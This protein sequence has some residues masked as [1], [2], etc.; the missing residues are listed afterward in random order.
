MVA[1]IHLNSV[2]CMPTASNAQST[3]L[4]Q[5]RAAAGLHEWEK[6]DLV[7][8]PSNSLD[9]ARDSSPPVPR[10]IEDPHL[11]SNY[12]LSYDRPAAD[13][14]DFKTWITK[15]F[16]KLLSAEEEAPGTEQETES[17]TLVP[18]SSN[19][20]EV[21]LPIDFNLL[22]PAKGSAHS[23]S[24]STSILNS[25]FLSALNTSKI[26]DEEEDEH[27]DDED[28]SEITGGD[29]HETAEHE[30]HYQSDGMVNDLMQSE[31]GKTPD[32]QD[33]DQNSLDFVQQLI[34]AES[35]EA[36]LVE[37]ASNEISTEL[38][39]MATTTTTAISPTGISATIQLAGSSTTPD[40]RNISYDLPE[41]RFLMA[42]PIRRLLMSYFAPRI[43]RF[44]MAM[45][46]NSVIGEVSRKV[47]DPIVSNLG[48]S[49]SNH[50]NRASAPPAAV[51]SP[52]SS[53]LSVSQLAQTLSALSGGIL[54]SSTS[55][56]ARSSPSLSPVSVL[57]PVGAL[58]SL[59]QV[60]AS[61]SVVLSPVVTSNGVGSAISSVSTS[62]M[63]QQQP[64]SSATA[65]LSSS[66]A[67]STIQL[68]PSSIQALLHSLNESDQIKQLISM[69]T[70]AVGGGGTSSTGAHHSARPS[71]EANR[72]EGT[73]LLTPT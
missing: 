73:A 43:L 44:Q 34:G 31:S 29:S 15:K 27:S 58:P 32:F 64:S 40:Y 17:S 4:Q 19:P 2:T 24:D 3:Y 50:A 66:V 7:N 37:P 33:F 6:Y 67:G 61:P 55:T 41:R 20:N 8:S 59:S 25:A 63:Q 12:M 53:A 62:S 26:V 45:L 13:K 10:S 14:P 69:A 51:S 72:K 22:I 11:F 21:F 71:S 23:S 35:R 47:L 49:V 38:P 30:A 18:R 5:N 46:L 70:S 56:S 54:P 9:H 28:D 1:S 68:S 60:S 39:P 57:S 16:N 48:F 52:A 42:Y 36:P 65:S